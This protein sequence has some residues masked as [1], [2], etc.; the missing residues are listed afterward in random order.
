MSV[1]ELRNALDTLEE[2]SCCSGTVKLGERLALALPDGDVGALGDARFVDWMLEHAEPAPYGHGTE[3]KLDP[4]V[5]SAQR[6]K[7]RDK[8]VV[9][10][11]DPSAILDDIAGVLSPT[12]ALSAQLTDVI[13]YG[14]GDKF[15]RHKD[16]PRVSNLIGTLVV[17]LPIAHTGGTFVIDDGRGPQ[18]FDWGTTPADSLPWVALFSDVD[19]EIEAVKSGTRVTL[20]YALHRT[21]QPRSDARATQRQAVVKRAAQA[22][23]GQRA[24]PV[25]IACGRHVIAEPE[26]KQPMSIDVLRGVDRDI[27]EALEDAGYKVAVRACIAAIPNYDDPQPWPD[28]TNMF[29]ITRLKAVPPLDVYDALADGIGGG[30]EDYLLD[31]V[32]LPQCA[33]RRTAAATVLHE[34]ATWAVGGMDF[35]N[36]GFD[37][38]LY[39]VAS[40]EVT[41]AKP[42]GAS[43]KQTKAPK[44][45]AAKAPNKAAKATPKAAKATPKAAKK[46]A[47]KAKPKR[48]R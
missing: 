25:L 30:I 14:K 35:G 46:P 24:W 28:T 12:R 6:M 29:E 39:S 42:G 31:E 47:P 38:L 18:R 36:E 27:A 48:K 19:H 44:K 41:K 4:K 26:E 22:L 20:V 13:V 5:R 33:I 3:T 8:I 7:A 11:F 15:T 43:S 16:T 37:A 45:V 1:E 40:I 23:S 32:M 17:G 21:E 2:A 34:R 9:H 10:G